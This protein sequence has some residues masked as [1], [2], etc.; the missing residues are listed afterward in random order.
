M[1]RRRLPNVYESERRDKN[2]WGDRDHLATEAISDALR[3][4]GRKYCMGWGQGRIVIE[5]KGTNLPESC[6]SQ[7]RKMKIR[8]EELGKMCFVRLG[9]F[10]VDRG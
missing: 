3:M 8:N 6:S 10:V 9:S 2:E 4:C 7:A 5:R 1:A